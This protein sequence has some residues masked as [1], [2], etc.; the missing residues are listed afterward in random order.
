M[1]W[2]A[3]THI[4]H[5][6]LTHFTQRHW[7]I[8]V[9]WENDGPIKAYGQDGRPATIQW[10]Y[11]SCLNIHYTSMHIGWI[12]LLVARY[13]PITKTR[14]LFYRSPVLHEVVL[15]VIFHEAEGRTIRGL[16]GTQRSANEDCVGEFVCLVQFCIKVWVNMRHVLNTTCITIW[17]TSFQVPLASR[18]RMITKDT[19]LYNHNW[20]WCI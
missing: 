12:S 15:V 13:M 2:A 10:K 19:W 7:N 1:P 6:K 17:I 3:C 18:W 4:T 20:L 8:G 16:I 9:K 14:T 11:Y 5:I